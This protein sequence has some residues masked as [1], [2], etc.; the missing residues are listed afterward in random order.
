VTASSVGRFLA[1]APASPYDVVFLDPPYSVTTAAVLL[2]LRA[3]V[4]NEWLGPMAVVVVERATRSGPLP[5]PDGLEAE[6]SR[7]YGESTLWYGRAD[8]STQS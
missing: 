4:G 2:D 1:A 3:L 6:R 8:I 5:W 7:R